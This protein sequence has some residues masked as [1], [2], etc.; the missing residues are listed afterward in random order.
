M[1]VE[2]PAETLLQG[3]DESDSAVYLDEGVAACEAGALGIA[4]LGF[5]DD[6]VDVT[7]RPLIS[8]SDIMLVLPVRDRAVEAVP[9]TQACDKDY[10][11]KSLNAE[12]AAL[13]DIPNTIREERRLYNAVPGFHANNENQ[14][15]F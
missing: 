2:L 8:I 11:L 9:W 10:R 15:V 3:T 1:D 5:L 14:V 12:L 4:Q 13:G 7:R 6:V